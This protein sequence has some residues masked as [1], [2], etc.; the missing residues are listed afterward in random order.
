[1]LRLCL[2]RVFLRIAVQRAAASDRVHCCSV[3]LLLLLTVCVCVFVPPCSVGRR[4]EWP[5][6]LEE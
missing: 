2:R 4:D 1:M 5:S 3:W 6:S